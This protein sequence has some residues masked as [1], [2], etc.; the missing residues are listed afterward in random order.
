MALQAKT[1]ERLRVYLK[2]SSYHNDIPLYEAILF[3]ARRVGIAGGTVTKGVLGFGSE[4]WLRGKSALV[5]AN[6]V[7]MK[8][9]LIDS[10]EIL[11]L[12]LPFL[13]KNLKNGLITRE[14]LNILLP[15]PPKE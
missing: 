7:P 8:V 12:I 11:N 2:N 9:E 15:E 6:N 13:E 10:P 3:E 4:K 14:P 1:A 5:P